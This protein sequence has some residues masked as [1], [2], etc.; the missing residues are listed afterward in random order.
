MVWVLG[1]LLAIAALDTVPD[2]PAMNPRAVSVTS[3]LGEVRSD[4]REP[5]F[6]S[7]SPISSLLQVRWTAFTASYDPNLP[8]DR[9][10]L[11]GFATDPSP[12]AV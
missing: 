8:E 7:D 3:L 11:A 6:N 2:P 12:P 10:I 4:V 5:K 1:L 9:I